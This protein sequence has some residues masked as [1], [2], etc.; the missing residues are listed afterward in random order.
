MSLKDTRGV[1]T[2]GWHSSKHGRNFQTLQFQNENRAMSKKDQAAFMFAFFSFFFFFL[3]DQIS[4]PDIQNQSESFTVLIGKCHR[5]PFRQRLCM[6][7]LTASPPFLLTTYQPQ[8]KLPFSAS[9]FSLRKVQMLPLRCAQP[10]S[11]HTY[12]CFLVFL[13]SGD[14][15]PIHCYVNFSP[16]FAVVLNILDWLK[17]WSLI[18]SFWFHIAG[19][20]L[21]SVFCG[22]WN[23]YA[24]GS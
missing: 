11:T 4:D 6:Q 7:N 22:N 21:I 3:F 16:F 18:T 10:K 1:V 19:L 5:W 13:V 2:V 20:D 12:T 8:H 24:N 14:Q 9:R 17:P 15:L 23:T